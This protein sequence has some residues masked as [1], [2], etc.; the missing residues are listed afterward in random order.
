M[1]ENYLRLK[2]ERNQIKGVLLCSVASFG[3][4]WN[5]IVKPIGRKRD[6][7]LQVAKIQLKHT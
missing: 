3:C 4:T 5:I 6:L 2:I 7:L 1:K